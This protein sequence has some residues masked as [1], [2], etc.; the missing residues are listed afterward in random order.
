MRKTCA[1]LLWLL[2]AA[3]APAAEQQYSIYTIAG[4]PP[5]LTPQPA[6]D[7][8]IG[9]AVSVA[10][11]AKGNVYFASADLNSVFR[12]DANGTVI[13]VAGNTIAG[14]TGDG[15]T[16]TCDQPNLIILVGVASPGGIAVDL[17][18]Y[19]TITD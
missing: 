6:A 7:A 9:F 11:D 15:G 17:S 18:G 16:A 3:P 12:L 2:T 8:A 5:Q 13:R 14:F 1:I 10:A 4:G 19:R